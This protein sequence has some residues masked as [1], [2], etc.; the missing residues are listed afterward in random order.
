MSESEDMDLARKG[1]LDEAKFE[2]F[3]RDAE[4][5]DLRAQVARLEKMEKDALAAIDETRQWQLEVSRLKSEAEELEE[6]VISPLES[7]LDSIR[8]FVRAGLAERE[9]EKSALDARMRELA[10]VISH[11]ASGPIVAAADRVVDHCSFARREAIDAL[12]A[13]VLG[14]AGEEEE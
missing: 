11:P 2:E 9:A 3:S 5:A 1:E 10:P 8:P 12:P 4:V 13:D 14:W 6:E 7:R